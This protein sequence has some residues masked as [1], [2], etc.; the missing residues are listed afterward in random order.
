M[1]SKRTLLIVIPLLVAAGLLGAIVLFVGNNTSAA[2]APLAQATSTF[3]PTRTPLA[4]TPTITDTEEVTGTSTAEV[5]GTVEPTD[6]DIDATQVTPTATVTATPV[7]TD[8]ETLTVT[9]TLPPLEAVFQI[10]PTGEITNER[11]LT[12]RGT[13]QA[14]ADPDQARVRIGYSTQMT[15]AQDAV[16]QVNDQMEE[17]IAALQ[18]AGVDEDDIQTT[19]F[20]IFSQ[21]P[22]P[23]PDVST[24]ADEETQYEVVQEVSVLIRD[25]DETGEILDAAISAGANRL[26]DFRFTLSETAAL[27]Q[28][29]RVEAMEDVYLRAQQFATLADV[30]LAGVV[31]I[32]ELNG[33][34]PIVLEADEAARAVGAGGAP[35]HAGQLSVTTQVE[36]VFAIR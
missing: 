19:Q 26:S 31:S 5:T 11:T 34:G 17:I 20:N 23:R 30:E 15:S 21:Q 6:E 35:V 14:S 9:A 25:R 36:V 16:T 24:T 1:T 32:R 8:T 2:A 27:E 22:E 7:G 10:T 28:Q 13:G 18:D 4:E 3:R 12:V 29:A 33:S